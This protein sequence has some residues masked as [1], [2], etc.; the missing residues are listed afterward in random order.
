MPSVLATNEKSHYQ[1]YYYLKNYHQ[2]KP[3]LRKANPA[4]FT[5]WQNQSIIYN[6]SNHNYHYQFSYTTSY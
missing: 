5:G 3:H 6:F 1:A 4:H 2:K